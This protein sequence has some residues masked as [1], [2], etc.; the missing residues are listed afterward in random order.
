MLSRLKFD[1][2]CVL[3]RPALAA[4]GSAATGIAIALAGGI[5][6]YTASRI[7]ATH[8]MQQMEARHVQEIL[9]VRDTYGARAQDTRDSVRAAADATREAAQ[10]TQAIAAELGP[11]TTRAARRAG[12]SARK[13]REAADQAEQASTTVERIMQPIIAPQAQPQPAE[14]PAWLDGP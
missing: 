14:V 8:S 2:F 11:E 3:N 10:A 6:G 12:E 13:A 1:R 5:A 7:E 4:L 9:A